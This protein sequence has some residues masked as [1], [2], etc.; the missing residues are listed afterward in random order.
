LMKAV[1]VEQSIDDMDTDITSTL[2]H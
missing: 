2:L 1:L